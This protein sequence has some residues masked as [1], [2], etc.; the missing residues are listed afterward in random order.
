MYFQQSRKINEE[1]RRLQTSLGR[2]L[3]PPQMSQIKP[4]RPQARI[5]ATG[6]PAR[7]KHGPLLPL[8]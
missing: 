4:D 5:L 8:I 1:D 2:L 3:S 6:D 7:W